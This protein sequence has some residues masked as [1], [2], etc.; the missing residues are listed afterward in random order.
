MIFIKE[1]FKILHELSSTNGRKQKENIIKQN[2]NNKLFIKTLNFLLNPYI[3]TNISTKKIDKKI[4]KINVQNLIILKNID[5]FFDYLTNKCTGKNVDIYVVQQFI[6][7]HKEYKE[8]LKALATK[9]MKLGITNKTVNKVLGANII[10]QFECQL[11]ESYKTYKNKVQGENFILTIKLNGC[12]MIAFVQNGNVELRTRVGKH[13][14][15]NFIEIK[16]DLSKLPNGVYDGECLAIGAFKTNV[17]QYQAT[18]KLFTKKGIVRG[19]KFF[20]YDY[21]E[22][23]EDFKNGIS[24]IS[25]LD[26]KNKL[27]K[28]LNDDYTFVKYLKPLYIGTD[29][30]EIE[31]QLYMA[32]NNFEEGIM[33]S[34]A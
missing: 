14:A 9:S 4:D 18:K 24:Y 20:C 5:V 2:K 31:K 16:N 15:G 12:K 21:V 30:N 8:E 19:L 22:N 25:T 23:I 11:A 34:I 17:E 7:Q 27:Q 28:I 13:L 1:L 32:L 6:Q 3:T 10:P 29:I 33:V 26:R